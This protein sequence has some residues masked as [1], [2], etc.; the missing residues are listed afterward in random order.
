LPRGRSPAGRGE[1]LLDGRYL[2]R[3]HHQAYLISVIETLE[4]EELNTAERKH[5]RP[6]W[7]RLLPPLEK[8]AAPAAGASRIRSTG[9]RLVR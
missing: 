1:L 6:V 3:A 5:Y 4:T 9:N 7:N 8:S 2:E